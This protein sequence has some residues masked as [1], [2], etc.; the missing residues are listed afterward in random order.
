MKT[1]VPILIVDDRP[2]NLLVL[3]S[4]LT[5]PSYQLVMVQTAD[6][7]LQALL[8]TEFAAVLLDV[9]MPEMSGFQL[10]RIIHSRRAN[11]SLPI[12]F[13]S[14][15]RTDATDM[16]LG[17]ESGG[18]D[19]LAKPFDPNVVRA[20]VEIFANLYR[21]RIALTVEAATLRGENARLQQIV[22]KQDGPGSSHN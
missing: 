7:A 5:L 20:K 18:V 9:K 10:A 12:I 16:M 17:Y 4:V 8:T 3:E 11:R 14:A 1:I 22:A 19:Y 6:E 13:L 2:K 21:Q 15:H